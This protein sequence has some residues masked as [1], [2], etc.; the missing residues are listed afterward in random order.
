M[1]QGFWEASGTHPTKIDL[2]TSPPP[3]TPGPCHWGYVFMLTGRFLENTTDRGYWLR[4]WNSCEDDLAG[5]ANLPGLY[6]HPLHMW[7][8]L[9]S[10]IF[11]YNIEFES[12]PSPRLSK[13]LLD[14]TVCAKSPLIFLGD[15]ACRVPDTDWIF[16]SPIYGSTNL[17][18]NTKEST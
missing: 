18:C 5:A 6:N 14:T 1:G 7:V 13:S 4:S 16:R 3:P 11:M 8:K 10:P 12:V 17:L 2:S 15:L 9:D